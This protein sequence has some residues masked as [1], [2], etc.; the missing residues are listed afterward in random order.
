MCRKGARAVKYSVNMKRIPAALHLR[1]PE[2]HGLIQPPLGDGAVANTEA[3]AEPGIAV[4]LGGDAQRVQVL[5]TPLHNL[6]VGYP[7]AVADADKGG[8]SLGV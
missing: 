1:L 7:I 4:E 2:C 3:V 6:P 8:R 5:Y